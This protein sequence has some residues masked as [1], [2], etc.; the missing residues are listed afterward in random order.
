LNENLRRFYPL[1][2]LLLAFIAGSLFTGLLFC[3]QRSG[4]I[5][6]LD[7]RYTFEHRK[8][9]EIIGRLEEELGREREHNKRAR[10]LAEGLTGASERNVRNLQDA[11]GLI[12]EIREKIKILADFYT[13]SDTGN[14]NS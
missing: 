5:G 4:S 2:F 6:E 13:N 1:L 10:E 9:T 12:S 3:R 8:A 7:S 11:V 14:S